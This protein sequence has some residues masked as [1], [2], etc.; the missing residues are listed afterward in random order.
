[1]SSY[2]VVAGPSSSKGG[3]ICGPEAK[4]AGAPFEAI[5]AAQAKDGY[6]FVQVFAHEVNGACCFIIPK[7]AS[8]NLLVF[9]KG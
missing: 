5:I 9:R 8:V 4:A 2:R 7:N 6:Q 1:M 3:M